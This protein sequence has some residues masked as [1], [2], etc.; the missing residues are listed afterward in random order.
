MGD[1][2][3]GY[4]LCR[5]FGN[6]SEA[7]NVGAIVF[8]V[9]ILAVTVLGFLAARW[10]GSALDTLDQWA[11]GGRQFGTAVSW[12]LMGGDL[13]TAYTFIAVPALAFGSGALAFF[14]VPYATITYPF[15]FVALTRFWGLARKHGYVT[16]AD[17]VQDRFRS[18]RLEIAVGVTGVLATMPYI[19]LQLVGMQAVL[20]RSGIAP[21]HGSASVMLFGAFALLAGYTYVSGLRAPALIAFVKDTLIYGTIAVALW[22]IPPALGGWGHV[23]SAAQA[24]LAARPKPSSI[25][26]AP[27]LYFAYASLALGSAFALFIYPH[28]ITSILSAKSADVV[29]KNCALLPLYTLL[30]GFLALLGYCA[31]AAHLTPANANYAIP[32][33]FRKFF[34]NW[35]TGV[36][37]AAIVIGALVPAAIMAIGAANLFAGNI[38]QSF[39]S[40]GSS[41]QSQT[42]VARVLALAVLAG[43]FCIATFVKTA[44]AIDFQ[45]LGGAWILQIL[46][47]FVLS[48]YTR[49]FHRDALFAGWIAGM[50]AATLM[51]ISTGFTPLFALRFG[52][53]TIL[54]AIVLY[55]LLVNLIVSSLVTLFL[56]RFQTFGKGAATA[57]AG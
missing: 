13:Y 49:W 1:R 25:L 57:D 24:V 7:V 17:F 31:L 21:S 15:V 14:A 30:L 55:S 33:L 41:T 9:L 29:R 3:G 40:R 44:F 53:T 43:A 11:L 35:F 4:R 56:A 26:L 27:N 48:M 45:L 52:S 22:V 46:P 32:D 19:A 54:G 39:S 16:A 50:C 12:F 36:A 20:E 23:F 6:E 28:S 5:F 18:R 10:R 8:A 47:A 34:P 51:A 38:L 2:N 42:Q 37:F